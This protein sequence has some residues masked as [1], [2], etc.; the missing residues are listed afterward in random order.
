MKHPKLSSFVDAQEQRLSST[1][2]PSEY[3]SIACFR[4][5]ELKNFK[6]GNKQL[7]DPAQRQTKAAKPECLK[8]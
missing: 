6:V 5:K 3:A 2:G 4:R 1:L 8:S 7:Q